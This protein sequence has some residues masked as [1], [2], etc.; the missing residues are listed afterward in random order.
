MAGSSW[1]LLVCL[2]SILCLSTLRAQVVAA[3]RSAAIAAPSGPP[4]LPLYGTV[5]LPHP[6]A[7][8]SLYPAARGTITFP[9]I[10]S[11]AGIIFSGRVT[12]VGLTAEGGAA[13]SP[14]S[15]SSTAVNFQVDYAIR[16]TAAGQSL[17]IHEW[18][19]L[20]TRDKKRYRIG[21]HVFL[22]LYSPS[23]WGLTSPVAGSM[24]KFAID[25]HGR[26]VANAQN[27]S[28][29]AQDPVIGGKQVVPYT[30]FI[31]AVRRVG[32]LE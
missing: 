16:G 28:A 14:G 10:V 19:G 4:S 13:P 25:N 21:E 23:K 20:W 12:S 6:G 2:L 26:I 7:A 9:Q 29:L 22:F 11:T 3:D 5:R 17:T 24:G 8:S 30:D 15:V 18:S 31:Q 1:R 32:G 27:M